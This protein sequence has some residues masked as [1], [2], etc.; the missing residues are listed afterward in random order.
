M[1][2]LAKSAAVET[3]LRKPEDVRFKMHVASI[4]NR[5]CSLTLGS[6]SIAMGWCNAPV[7]TAADSAAPYL[8][9]SPAAQKIDYPAGALMSILEREGIDTGALFCDPE[10][11]S[12]IEKTIAAYVDRNITFPTSRTAP[13]EATNKTSPAAITF[14]YLDSE[15]TYLRTPTLTKGS[16]AEIRSLLASCDPKI[17]TTII[18]D[19]RFCRH[20]NDTNFRNY[21]ELFAAFPNIR[22][23]VLVN[24]ETSGGFE[25][26]AGLLQDTRNGVILG[27]KTAGQPYQRKEIGLP[28]GGVIRFPLQEYI[29][30]SGKP[31]AAAACVPTVAYRDSL[32]A[33]SFKEK[34]HDQ[35][36]IRNDHG[37]QQAMELTRA[38]RLFG[39]KRF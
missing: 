16:L 38:Y 13:T 5:L 1:L 7:V 18:W 4:T 14:F 11:L 3:I 32:D 30:V 29:S 35:N 10:L 12:E 33:T 37:I 21:E 28:N 2:S 15:S 27:E 22:Y 39:K 24:R 31:V 20:F 8:P 23:I 9:Q 17:T 26:L 19:F 25:I 36:L 34:L 6:I